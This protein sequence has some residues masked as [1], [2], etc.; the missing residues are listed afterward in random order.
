[1]QAAA[2]AR[3]TSTPVKEVIETV[4]GDYAIKVRAAREKSGMTQA[5]FAKALN[6]KE[7]I[8]QKLETGT[9]HPPISMARKLEKMLKITLVQIEEEEKIEGEKK[10]SGSLTIGDLINLK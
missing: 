2:Q 1:M 3:K 10:T 9:F 4:A 5:D 6:E 8:I 7:S